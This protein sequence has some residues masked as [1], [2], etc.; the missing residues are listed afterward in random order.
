MA[1]II[2]IIRLVTHTP[3]TIGMSKNET[4]EPL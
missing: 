4:L 1:Q 2:H 3:M